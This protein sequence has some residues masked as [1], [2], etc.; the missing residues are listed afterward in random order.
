MT[1]TLRQVGTNLSPLPA[2][3]VAGAGVT[4][5]ASSFTIPFLVVF[6]RED[7]GLT[8]GTTGFV[9]GSSVFFSIFSAFVGGS[10]S[11]LVGRSRLLLFSLLGVAASFVGF[12]LSHHLTTVI[13]CNAALA[14][15]NSPFAPVAKALLGDL[16]P[17]EGRARWFR[18]QYLAVNAGYAIGPLIGAW[19]GASGGRRAFLA[20]AAVYAAYAV[21]LMATFLVNS[22]GA[23]QVRPQ[24]GRRTHIRQAVRDLTDSFHTVMADRRLLCVIVAGLLLDAVYSRPVA[25]LAQDMTT[26]S[27]D[28][29]TAGVLGS[30]V[31]ANAVTVVLFQLLAAR[32][33]RRVEP[34]RSLMLGGAL[35]AVGMAGFALSRPAWQFIASMCVFAIG[36][37]LVVPAEFAVIDRLAPSQRRGGYFGAQTLTQVGDFLGPFTGGLVLSRFGGQAMFLSVGAFALLGSLIYLMGWRRL[38]GP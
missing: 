6:L 5:L 36:E 13:A 4:S 26:G 19:A 22:Q 29:G 7:I 35:L 18:Y 25:L 30:V 1:S 38:S 16:L 34:V 31:T 17:R 28:T 32:F 21:A 2:V 14:F 23:A 24:A 3:L 11:D 37:T 33:T 10:L 20:S 27:H 15:C 9:I 12:S 8:T